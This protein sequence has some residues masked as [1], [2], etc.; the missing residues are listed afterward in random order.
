MQGELDRMNGLP[1]HLCRWVVVARL[2]LTSYTAVGFLLAFLTGLLTLPPTNLSQS[3]GVQA[4]LAI[5]SVLDPWRSQ[6]ICR[7]SGRNPTTH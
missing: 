3:E 5:V 4:L 7:G 6:P 2:W 1:A